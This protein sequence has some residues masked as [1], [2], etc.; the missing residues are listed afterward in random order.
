MG[1][2]KL[3]MNRWVRTHYFCLQ[4]SYNTQSKADGIENYKWR[5]VL[6]IHILCKLIKYQFLYKMTSHP[7]SY[8]RESWSPVLVVLHLQV[9]YA[10][11]SERPS[12]TPS[13]WL[14]L[15]ASSTGFTRICKFACL[16]DF[17]VCCCFKKYVSPTPYSV[18]AK[19]V[20][21]FCL[22]ILLGS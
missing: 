21:M 12:L 9:L 15:M 5:Q 8:L 7:P 10:T 22:F 11:S 14:D 13:R 19:V 3:V 1:L 17:W 18:W 20:S 6:F 4:L 16:Y 2:I